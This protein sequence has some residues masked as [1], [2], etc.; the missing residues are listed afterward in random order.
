[1]QKLRQL[2]KTI[3]A[4]NQ[5]FKRR[6]VAEAVSYWLA[7]LAGCR[8]FCGAETNGLA[9]QNPP[10][11]AENRLGRHH[12]PAADPAQL[13]ALQQVKPYQHTG[14]SNKMKPQPAGRASGVR[15]K[16][17]AQIW[18]RMLKLAWPVVWLRRRLR[19]HKI[20]ITRVE[21][22]VAGGEHPLTVLFGAVN[23]NRDYLLQ[24]MFKE[25]NRETDNE[26]VRLIDAFQPE[27]SRERTVDMVMLE[28]NQALHGWLNDGSWFIIPTWVMGW[29]PLPPPE[30]VLRNDTIRSIGRRIRTHG[31]EYEVTHDLERFK[32]Y[33]DNM[34]LPYITKSYG[35]TACLESFEEMRE[36]CQSAGFE[37]ILLRKKSRPDIFIAGCLVTHEADGPRLWSFGVRDGSLELLREGVLSSLYL[38]CFEHMKSKG[39]AEVNMGGSRPFLRDGVLTMKKRLGHSLRRGRWEGFSLKILKL[40]HGT[41]SFLI[42]NPFVFQTD[43]RLHGAVFTE[44]PLTRETVQRLE[45][46]HFYPGL[47]KLLLY[48][49]A[50]DKE[51]KVADLPP[52]VAVR[53]EV[54]NAS[55]VVSG[56]L[57]LP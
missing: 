16:F 37:L 45:R 39:F 30:K 3:G 1:M 19:P 17:Q 31:H 25:V 49:F 48:F 57:H 5:I 28:T 14:F 40:T 4:G 52:E 47:G 32:D 53:V 56:D 26:T 33:F 50:W 22:I 9:S 20:S 18:P 7:I 51:F 44:E 42:N 29:V 35:E 6:K 15:E 36:R 10:A 43:E 41:K 55:E 38:F 11:R 8:P 34:H 2:L 27:F 24:L 23:Q 46:E 54:R 12:P 21:G 13:N